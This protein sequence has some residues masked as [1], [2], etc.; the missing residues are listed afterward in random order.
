MVPTNTS[1][2]VRFALLSASCTRLHVFA[3]DLTMVDPEQKPWDFDNA[4]RRKQAWQMIENEEPT[5]IIGTPMCT[6]FIAWQR[7]HALRQDPLVVG[8][9]YARALVHLGFC[10]PV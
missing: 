1:V 3:N 8:R 4:A 9:E 6:A 7:I 2:L 10:M 5:L